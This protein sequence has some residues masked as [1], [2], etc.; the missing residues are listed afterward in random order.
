VRRT[1]TAVVTGAARG[2]GKAAAP[3]LAA[4][5]ADVAVGR[6]A[7]SRAQAAE[8]IQTTGRRVNAY[9]CDVSDHEAV[10]RTAERLLAPLGGEAGLE[11]TAGTNKTNMLMSRQTSRV[12]GVLVRELGT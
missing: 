12:E 4:C 7:E 8:A 9:G 2:I 11:S 5:G 3:G 6:S 1:K 10:R